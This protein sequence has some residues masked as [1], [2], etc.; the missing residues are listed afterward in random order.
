V[1]LPSSCPR[2]ARPRAASIASVADSLAQAAADLYSLPP[3]DFTAARDQ[4][5]KQ[6][7]AA[8]Q[9][10]DA[11]L[12][13]KLTR[14]TVSAWLVNQFVRTAPASMDRLYELARELH[15]AQQE[16]AGDRLRELS[17]QRRQL[18]AEL[19]PEVGRVAADA[20]VAASAAALDEV[21]ATLEAALADAG[22]R[23]AVQ[24]GQLTRALSYAGIGEVDLAAALAV[25][26]AGRTAGPGPGARPAAAGQRS[27]P[28][29]GTGGRGG[30]SR[31][32]GQAKEAG[33]GSPAAESAAE[34]ARQDLAEAEAEVAAAAHRLEGA[35][36]EVAA[37]SEQR[38]FLNRRM[39]QLREELAEAEAEGRTL[40]KAA[41]DAQRGRDAAARAVERAGR[42][43][44]HARQRTKKP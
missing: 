18:I 32:S 7:R 36:S 33:R 3:A 17:A 24:T 15:A 40:A 13:K 35:E 4:L 43:L 22:A 2:P 11:A 39:E 12:I 27:A 9:R 6:A 42:L 19:M 34:R 28:G 38:Q 14:P 23:A 37:V 26:P 16:L 44:T 8:G 30:A 41:R 10:D 25:I 31:G 5:A 29:T 1:A 21:R 20:G